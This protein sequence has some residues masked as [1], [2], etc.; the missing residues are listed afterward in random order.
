MGTHT[1]KNETRA[2]ARDRALRTLWTSLGI[3]AVVA[4]GLV[5]NDW[6]STADITDGTA[7]AALG[8]LVGKSVIHSIAS[9]VVRL[10]VAPAAG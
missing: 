3:D 9:Y 8:V 10:K 6:I 4:V 5:L 1:A 7:W 2:D